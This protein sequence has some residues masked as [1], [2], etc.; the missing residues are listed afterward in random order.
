MNM[1]TNLSKLENHLYKVKTKDFYWNPESRA[2]EL[3][4][5]QNYD[6]N[7]KLLFGDI[8]F[9]LIIKKQK[10]FKYFDM[11]ILFK[12]RVGYISIEQNLKKFNQYFKQIEI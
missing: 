10:H 8:F 1:K 11:K 4:Y 2:Q 5:E 3:V 12:N 7:D 9:L 6:L